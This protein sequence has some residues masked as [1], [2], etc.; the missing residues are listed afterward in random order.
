MAAGVGTP[1][2]GR[3]RASSSPNSK[4]GSEHWLRSK[5]NLAGTLSTEVGLR[6]TTKGVECNVGGGGKGRRSG[7][8]ARL[9]PRD[10]LALV[11]RRCFTLRSPK[12]LSCPR[13][14]PCLLVLLRSSSRSLHRGECP[15]ARSEPCQM[16]PFLDFS[17]S[18]SRF[19]SR[20]LSLDLPLSLPGRS[21]D[22]GF[23]SELRQRCLSHT[24]LVSAVLE[25]RSE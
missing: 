15:R 3:E 16:S 7:V 10:G 8:W 1:T 24:M 23:C 17:R 5:D 18:P 6:D 14:R 2:E 22:R 21:A 12:L 4:G 19:L 13:K 25:W 11:P 9:S 20:S